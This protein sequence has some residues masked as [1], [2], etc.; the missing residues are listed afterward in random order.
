MG[1]SLDNGGTR[2]WSPVIARIEVV[3]EARH[4][5]VLTS[6]VLPPPLHSPRP[7]RHGVPT[8]FGSGP[9]HVGFRWTWLPC[10]PPRLPGASAR[11]LFSAPRRRVV[12]FCLVFVLPPRDITSW[13]RISSATGYRQARSHAS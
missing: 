3:P 12:V 13:I 1:T 6:L 9:A 5:S 10:R 7:T 11:V 8:P 4:W 2:E